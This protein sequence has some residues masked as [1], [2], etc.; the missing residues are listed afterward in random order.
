MSECVY[1]SACEAK[2]R[3]RDGSLT[4]EACRDSLRSF[5]RRSPAEVRELEAF[6]A[7]LRANRLAARLEG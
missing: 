4:C 3:L 6:V 5:F 1:C 2:S 7:Q